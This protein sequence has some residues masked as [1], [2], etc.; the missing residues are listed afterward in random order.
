[1]WW[2]QAE[3]LVSALTMY[4]LTKDEAYAADFERV[5]SW[6]NTHQT[7][8]AHGDWHNEVLPD[9]TPRGDKASAWKEAY[10]ETRG[11]LETLSRLDNLAELVSI[12]FGFAFVFDCHS[13]VED[14]H[15]RRKRTDGARSACAD[16]PTGQLTPVPPSPQYP[17]GFLSRYC[18]WY[19]SA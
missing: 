13:V 11:L 15:E 12:V 4:S 1:M 18:W 10:H 7:D 6:V 9:G 16:T 3:A 17:P 14:E 8:W 5:W 19:S 2:V